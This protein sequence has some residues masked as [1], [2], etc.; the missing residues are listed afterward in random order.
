MNGTPKQ[1]ASK[2][3]TYFPIVAAIWRNVNQEGKAWYSVNIERRYKDQAGAWQ[4][5]ASF[6]ADDLLTVAKVANLAHTEA[7]KLIAADRQAQREP[8][9][10][11]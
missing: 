10:E 6:S 1:P 9:A 8:G 5:T 11:G 4:S 7:Y 2:V 3:E